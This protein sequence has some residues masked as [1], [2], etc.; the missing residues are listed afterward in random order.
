VSTATAA[1]AT[2]TVRWW[3]RGWHWWS[4]LRRWSSSSVSKRRVATSGLWMRSTSPIPERNVVAPNVIGS[5]VGG[6]DIPGEWRTGRSLLLEGI[7]G[8]NAPA[9]WLPLCGNMLGMSVV[10]SPVRLSWIVS[11]V[12]LTGW[13]HSVS[14]FG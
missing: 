4:L 5:P 8:T 7:V 3:S 9:C 13:W 10:S 2:M 1:A 12:V 6:W 11:G 14:R